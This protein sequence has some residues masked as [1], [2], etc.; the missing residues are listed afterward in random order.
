MEYWACPGA[1]PSLLRSGST[2]NGNHSRH[3][4]KDIERSRGGCRNNRRSCND[5]NVPIGDID[6]VAAKRTVENEFSNDG[7]MLRGMFVTDTLKILQCFRLEDVSTAETKKGRPGL[8]SSTIAVVFHDHD[9]HRF[10]GI[11]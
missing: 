5:L 2:G 4:I 6:R 10:Q 1:V 8:V 7:S 9:S 3:C 11:I